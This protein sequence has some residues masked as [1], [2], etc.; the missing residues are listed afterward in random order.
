M[1]EVIIEAKDPISEQFSVTK[2][3]KLDVYLNPVSQGDPLKAITILPASTN[4]DETANPSLRGSSPD[5]SRVILKGIP[6]YN[7][8]RASNISNHQGFFSLFNPEVMDNMYVYASNPPLTYGNTSAGMVEIKTKQNLTSNQLQFST[9]LASTGLFLSQNIKK[10]TSFVQVY[11]NYQF[12]DAFV[13]IQKDKLPSIKN[14]YNTDVGINFHTN[15]G[16]K[17]EFNSF[18][19]FIDESFNGTN[20]S[21]TYRGDLATSKKRIFTV[22]NLKYFFQEGVFSINSGTNKS[23]QDFEFGNLNSNQNTRQV[24]TSIYYRWYILE[25]TNLQFGVSHDYHQNKFKDSIPTFYY[26]LSPNSPVNLSKTD[27]D[28]HI[29]EA[30]L[31]TNWDIND[32]FSFSSGMRS[33]FPIEN[34]EFY[35]SSQLGLKYQ[36]NKKQRILLSGGRYHNYSIPN[37]YAK[38]Y[39]LLASR[40]AALDYSYD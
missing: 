28:N 26:A 13:G 14:F 21:F 5:R 20:Q 38:S 16:K 39:N 18:N 22:N 40:Q 11:G 31:Y 2:M 37:F 24:Y 34:Q 10:D 29:L 30:Y 7:P 23:T 6:I 9:S 32:K 35:F 27:I 17:G 4:T 15:I 19:Y 36:I 33:N 25:N 8:V 12:S 1:Q 3:D